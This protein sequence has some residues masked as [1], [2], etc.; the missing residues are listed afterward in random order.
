MA[1]SS[2]QPPPSSTLEPQPQETAA[3]DG[4]SA[5]AIAR[6]TAPLSVPSDTQIGVKIEDLLS[7]EGAR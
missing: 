2:S 3:G 7:K 6:G 4:V 5:A 1:D